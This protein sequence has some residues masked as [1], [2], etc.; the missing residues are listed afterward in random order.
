MG[1]LGFFGSAQCVVCS[2]VSAAEGSLKQVK[3]KETLIDLGTQ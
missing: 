1:L 3:K 2:D